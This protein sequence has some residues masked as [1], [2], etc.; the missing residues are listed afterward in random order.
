M[1]VARFVNSRPGWSMRN[2]LTNLSSEESSSWRSDWRGQRRRHCTHRRRSYRRTST[3]VHPQRRPLNRGRCF[4]HQRCSA[5]DTVARR[6]QDDTG[7][8]ATTSLLGSCISQCSPSDFWTI[9]ISESVKRLSVRLALGANFRERPTPLKAEDPL[10]HCGDWRRE[11]F[12]QACKC[13]DR[14][15]PVA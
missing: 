5:L 7:I 10:I 14:C 11:D 9:S 1:T 8:A 6:S 3:A 13:R 12:L 2:S 15:D 4:P